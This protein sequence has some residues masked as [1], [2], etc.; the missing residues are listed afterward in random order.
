MRDQ[1]ACISAFISLRRCGGQ[2]NRLGLRKPHIF[3][4]HQHASPDTHGARPDVRTSRIL[5][6]AVQLAS[7]VVGQ[8]S[9]GLVNIPNLQTLR[10]HSILTFGKFGVPSKHSMSPTPTLVSKCDFGATARFD[11]RQKERARDGWEAEISLSSKKKKRK[12]IKIFKS[13]L[14]CKHPRVTLIMKPLHLE[15][16]SDTCTPTIIQCHCFMCSCDLLLA[17]GT[18]FDFFFFIKNLLADKSA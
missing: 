17:N 12:E 9:L 10:I 13:V 15:S 3:R 6:E 11:Y 5:G 1:H 4:L 18:K 7:V 2:S 8:L 16:E 14:N